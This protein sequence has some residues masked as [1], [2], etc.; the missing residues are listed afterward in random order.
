MVVPIVAMGGLILLKFALQFAA[1]L[2]LAV[3]GRA[4]C[5]RRPRK[6]DAVVFRKPRKHQRHA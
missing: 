2:L 1:N 5:C 4:V 3:R 6:L